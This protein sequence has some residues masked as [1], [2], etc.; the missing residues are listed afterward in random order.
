MK[1]IFLFVFL[2][3]GIIATGCTPQVQD[4][5]EP[6]ELDDFAKCLNE[7]ELRMYGQYTCGVCRKQRELFGSSF[8]YVGEIECHPEGENPQTQLCLEKDIMK[9][10]TW[11]LE[12]DGV[13]VDRLEG[14]QTLETL[15]EFSGCSIE[16]T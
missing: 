10:P 8:H 12:K 9:T 15:S 5:P 7:N 13:E 2:V 16:G 4:N 14:Y 6:S 1:K 11:I 3:A